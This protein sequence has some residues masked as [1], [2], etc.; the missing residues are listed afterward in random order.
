MSENIL[1][2]DRNIV[3][4]SN[5]L[6]VSKYNLSANTIDILHLFLSQIYSEDQEFKKYRVMFFE[7]EKKL[8]REIDRRTVDR[9]C[10][11]LLSNPIRIEEIHNNKKI[12]KLYNWASKAIYSPEEKWLELEIHPDLKSYLLQLK[13]NFTTFDRLKT[14]NLKSKSAKRI[15]ML[16]KQYANMKSP[17]LKISVEDLKYILN[18][19]KKYIGDFR[20]FRE[21]VLKPA[22]EEINEKTE[23]KFKIKEIKIG[24]KITNL[25]FH[26]IFQKEKKQIHKSGVMEAEEW[27]Q[28]QYNHNQKKD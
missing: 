24:R 20:S 26:L 21:K 8:G 17:I 1:L 23:I 2:K 14:N 7:I 19:D 15:Y 18:L 13:K 4:L 28:K 10:Y 27:L 9:I 12:C 6:N 5:T 25:E 11:E 16:L 22:Q 3:K